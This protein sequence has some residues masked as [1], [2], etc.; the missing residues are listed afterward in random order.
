MYVRKER[1]GFGGGFKIP[2]EFR[3]K[4]EQAKK[5]KHDSIN[6]DDEDVAKDL[7]LV[8]KD[9]ILNVLNL[10]NDESGIGAGKTG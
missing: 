9:E 7:S 6:S 8:T 1:T 4:R 3:L 2:E 10:G 5:K